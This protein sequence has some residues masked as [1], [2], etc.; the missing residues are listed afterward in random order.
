MKDQINIREEIQKDSIF[1]VGR[2]FFV[3]GRDIIV[4]IDKNKNTPHLLYRGKTIRNVSVGLSNYVKIIKGFTEIIC[5][6]EGEYLEY[7]KDYLNKGYKNEQ[8][9]IKRKIKVVVFGFYDDER[10]QHGIKE[11]PLIDN[12]CRLLTKEE[13]EKL[14]KFNKNNELMV[15]IGVLLDEETQE[16]KLPVKELFAGHIGIFGNTGSG[17]SN[18]LAKIYTEL[19]KENTTNNKF[20]DK[21]IFVLIDFNGEYSEKEVLCKDKKIYN[22]LTKEVDFKSDNKYPISKTE[23]EKLEILSI[24]LD[25]TE[26]TQK[27]FLNRAINTDY[28]DMDNSTSEKEIDNIKKKINTILNKNDATFNPPFLQKFITDFTDIGFN[29]LQ[30]NKKIDDIHYNSNTRCFY[31][32]DSQSRDIYHGSNAKASSD[33]K[34]VDIFKEYF[35]VKIKG[36]SLTELQKIQV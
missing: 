13:F 10:F 5:K 15:N 17:K 24:L 30:S 2:F 9:K 36:N 21:S 25:A 23:I 29:L 31:I 28:F 16:I 6:V 8:D 20:K 11:M 14:H 22:L 3:N 32:K 1:I 12:E 4:E 33:N 18:T 34:V 7:D 35:D 26:K 27:P 19:F